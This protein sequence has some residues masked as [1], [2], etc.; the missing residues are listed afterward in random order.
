M[1]VIIF[2][3]LLLL[4]VL[5]V[6]AFIFYYNRLVRLRTGSETAWSQ[7]DVELARRANLIPNLVEAVQGYAGHER[8]V[9]ENVSRARSRWQEAATM[10]EKSQ[11]DSLL[12]GALKTLFAVAENY[13]ALL[14]THNFQQL[15]QQLA[16]IEARIA[17]ARQ[18][19]NDQVYHYNTARL[20]FPGN[21][22]A[23]IF[24]FRPRDLF[25]PEEPA[26]RELP[27]VGFAR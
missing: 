24:E 22:V 11:A 6:F 25:Q 4:F 14:A 8:G 1:F 7:I 13:P 18:R 16:E 15:Q 2:L 12:S 26:S 9:F 3:I 27:R 23:Q 21:L 17:S 5:P 19:Y 20:T 10:Q